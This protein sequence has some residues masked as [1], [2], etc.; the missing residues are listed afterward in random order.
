MFEQYRQGIIDY[1]KGVYPNE[2][3]IGITASGLLPIENKAIDKAYSFDVD[4]PDVELLALVHSHPIIEGNGNNDY[5][6]EADML[7]Q[8]NSNIPWG[9]C[10]LD[11]DG[12]EDLFYWGNGVPS[13]PFIGRPYRWGPTGTDGKGDC[14]AL[15]KDYYRHTYKIELDEQPRS[16]DFY[17]ANQDHYMA[18]LD[19][20]GFKLI[21]TSE[22]PIEGDLIFMRIRSDVV[23]HAGIYI[24]DG[25]IL[26]HL[27][28][29][30]SRIEGAHRYAPFM[31]CYARYREPLQ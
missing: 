15:I 3:V 28:L 9:L 6:S 25:K 27:D 13:P 4:W 22:Q 17:R 11:D 30:L 21:E 23:N 18:N 10:V 20:Q 31:A 24:G 19:R 14:F 1:L 16:K 29:Q 26:H 8:I 2:G 7:G 5:P 12:R